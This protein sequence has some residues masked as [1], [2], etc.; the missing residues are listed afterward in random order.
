MPLP[1]L[2]PTPSRSGIVTASQYNTDKDTAVNYLN[3][4]V[5]GQA[6]IGNADLQTAGIFSRHLAPTF[7]GT[8]LASNVTVNVATPVDIFTFT[9]NLSTE[10]ASQNFKIT[11]LPTSLSIDSV[12][13]NINARFY[14]VRGTTVLINDRHSFESGILFQQYVLGSFQDTVAGGATYTYKIQASADS[15]S[16]VVGKDDVNA[17]NS[18]YIITSA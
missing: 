17:T 15:G 6:K 11:F 12:S 7:V 10:S 3:N 14:L 16:F 13:G 4:N 1:S 9:I 8:N 5:I 2:T 18:L